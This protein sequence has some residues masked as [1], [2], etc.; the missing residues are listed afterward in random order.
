MQLRYKGRRVAVVYGGSGDGTAD[1][2]AWKGAIGKPDPV[3]KSDLSVTFG[4]EARGRSAVD[5][6]IRKL[7]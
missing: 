4:E 1:S 5:G 6:V 2:V 3:L 7:F